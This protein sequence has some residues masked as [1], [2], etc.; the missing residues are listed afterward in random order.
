MTL[1]ASLFN[2]ALIFA[3]SGSRDL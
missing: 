3:F 2:T 1:I